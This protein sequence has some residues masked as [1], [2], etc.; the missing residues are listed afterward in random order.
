MPAIMIRWAVL[1]TKFVI[2]PPS[3]L[4]ATGFGERHRDSDSYSNEATNA[5]DHVL[6]VA[7]FNGELTETLG[8]LNDEQTELMMQW[9]E[10]ENRKA[11]LE[12]EE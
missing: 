8:K 9:E 1:L 3:Q 5:V 10:L 6:K 7:L 4:T 11:Q 2:I 12:G